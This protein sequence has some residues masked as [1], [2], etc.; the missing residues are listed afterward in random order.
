MPW[1]GWNQCQSHSFG[2][3]CYF[4]HVS[5]STAKTAETLSF[6][7]KCDQWACQKSDPQMPKSEWIRFVWN[8]NNLFCCSLHHWKSVTKVE[9]ITC[10]QKF[11][12]YES[13]WFFFTNFICFVFL[14]GRSF[15]WE[16]NTDIT[17]KKY[18]AAFF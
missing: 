10:F 3:I 2:R 9:L 11:W 15:Y 16:S 7:S 5:P 1:I 8:T 12:N 13:A 6:K 17:E 4:F 18:F 14:R